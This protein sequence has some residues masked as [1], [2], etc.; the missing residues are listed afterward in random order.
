MLKNKILTMCLLTGCV[1]S[2]C[3]T[4][5]STQQGNAE[6]KQKITSSQEDKLLLPPNRAEKLLEEAERL[7]K[8]K[9]QQEEERLRLEEERRKQEEERIRE[10]ERKKNIAFNSYDITQVSGLTEE[11]LRAVLNSKKQYQGLEE[12][13]GAFIDAEQKYGVNA[14]ALVAIPALESGWNTSNRAKNGH[15]NIVG[16][17][18]E[19]DSDKGSVYSSKY[20]C[21]MDL[22]RQLKTYYLT[23]GGNC[24]NGV[25]T[26]EVNK[27]Y[28]ASSDWYK[29]IDKI[30]DELVA[31]YHKIYGYYE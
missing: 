22:A 29:K 11:E 24:Y 19:E 17:A 18:V 6:T 14:F 28:C 21:I 20:E 8:I 16:M 31:A 5:Q 4:I 7:S 27:K 3:I 10:I 25:S 23:P 2:S 26:S 13:A 1:C 30:G 15:N 12:L 9:K